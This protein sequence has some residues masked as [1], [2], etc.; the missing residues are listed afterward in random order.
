MQAPQKVLTTFHSPGARGKYVARKQLRITSRA[1]IW[2]WDWTSFERDEGGAVEPNVWLN[3]GLATVSSRPRTAKLNC[4]TR[5]RDGEQMPRLP[6][7]CSWILLG[8]MQALEDANHLLLISRNSEPVVLYAETSRPRAAPGADMDLNG[9]GFRHLNRI[10]DQILKRL[11]EMRVAHRE[12]RQVGKRDEAPRFHDR[13][14][15]F[16]LACSSA[17]FALTGSAY[18]KGGLRVG[19]QVPNSGSGIAHP[20][21]PYR[22]HRSANSIVEKVYSPE[23]RPSGVLRRSGGD[24][25][26]F[27]I[28]DHGYTHSICVDAKCW[29]GAVAPRL[30]GVPESTSPPKG[31]VKKNVEPCRGVDSAHIVPPYRS[32]IRLQIA[33]PTP[34]PGNCFLWSRLNMP[35]I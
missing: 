20:T 15:R 8:A 21:S 23:D 1:A 4:V 27:L 33:R 35:N 28:T 31:S 12:R 34:V 17:A 14:P 6:R 25:Q 10:A 3:T 9:A 18:G 16:A 22:D 32:T 7:P 2:Q 29:Y 5:R 13:S 19:E 26:T 24:R 30:D 11:E